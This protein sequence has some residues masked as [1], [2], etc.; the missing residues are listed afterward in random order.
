MMTDENVAHKDEFQL[1]GGGMW[2]GGEK[3]RTEKQR[4]PA[5]AAATADPEIEKGE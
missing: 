3:Y 2:A 1:V 4:Q 5:Q